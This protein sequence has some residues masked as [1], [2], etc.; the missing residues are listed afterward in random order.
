MI[1]VQLARFYS[2][3]FDDD[4]VMNLGFWVAMEK[5]GFIPLIT[6]LWLLLVLPTLCTASIQLFGSLS[7]GFQA[8]QMGYIDN[9]GLFLLSN[10]A[11]FAFGF[12]PTQDVT[13][14]LL[15]IIH[16][17]TST[18]IWTANRGN[19]I[20]NSDNFVFDSK[21][22]VTL[23]AR[24]K[25]V[26][27][28]ETDGKSVSSIQLKNSGNLV[29][30]GSDNSTVWQTFSHPTN[31]LVS[32]QGFT[33]GMKLSSDPDVGNGSLTYFLEIKSGD[34][35]LYARY[36]TPQ[37]YWSMTKDT[38]KII[39]QDGGEVSLVKIEANS[40]RFYDQNKVLLWQFIFS[41]NPNPGNSTWIAVL[42]NDGFI[43]FYSLGL[44]SSKVSSSVKIPSDPCRT[45]EPCAAYEAC[46]SNRCQCPS[47]L[48]SRSCQTGISSPCGGTNSSLQLI[49]AGDG[50]SY[51]AL[52]FVQPSSRTTLDGCK[53]SCASNCSC[54]AVFFDNSSRS[55]YLF[56]RIGSFLSDSTSKYSAY[57]KV[58]MIGNGEVGGDS[59]NGNHLAIIIVIVI[60]TLL[61]IV[62][63]IY[64][65]YR[66]HLRKNKLPESPP[67]TS[68][69]DNFLGTLSGMP[70]RYSYKELQDATNNFSEKLGQGGFGSV[71]RG[72]LLDGTRIAV[73]KLEGVGQGKKEFRAE[74][75]IIGSIH[76]VHLVRLRGFCAEGNH[77]LLAY[78]F[79]ANGSLD[80]WIFKK[81]KNNDSVL[82]WKTRYNI[83][84]GTAK[85]LAYLHE[86]CDAKILHCDIKPENVLLDG[87]FE[88]KV[89]DFGLAKLMSRDQ[90]NVFTTL[91][92]TRGY[93]APE[94]IL[95]YPISE[96]SDV[97]SFGMVLLEI[98]GGRKNYDADQS[99]EKSHLP[100][101]AF[102]MM[103]Q[104]KLE[105]ILDSSL[106][107]KPY[108]ESV[109]NAIKVA[110][111]CI[112]E[113]TSIRPSMTKVVQMLEGL[114][115]VPH[116]PMT[117]FSGSRLFSTFFKSMSEEGTA[118][119]TSS[120]PSDCNSYAYMSAERLSGPR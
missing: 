107:Y 102:K 4:S 19:P 96:K 101:Y 46:S 7:P 31:T 53:N 63:I 2:T 58:S 83:A 27:S 119:G 75:S 109:Q 106:T 114:C 17:E 66:Y 103:E 111:W 32:N 93:L 20:A 86:D 117:S 30:Q 113:D 97:Y 110:L 62:G 81:K 92:G 5:W 108:D 57:V 51:F 112:Q 69:E 25:V 47:G 59:S 16:Q 9:D 76:H 37:V 72:V 94:W 100:S 65:G 18:V 35:N 13:L 36:R 77:R 39:N 14:F 78:E 87:H 116:P 115:P 56:D 84:L 79:M 38:R 90:S 1:I 82:D 60:V 98:I 61:V 70:V 105:E 54:L 40:W 71:Y 22:R 89:S 15:V 50:L 21:G 73:K 10:D 74:V 85:G 33:Q 48:L 12:K 11:S 34:L 91:R 55:C 8:S 3:K 80:K 64:G 118:T 52:G 68:E 42:G 23:Q 95:N 28:P 44:G 49:Y 29:F 45:P 26:W 99:S 88:A 43:T 41:S 6:S 24:G 120:G 104:G 67:E